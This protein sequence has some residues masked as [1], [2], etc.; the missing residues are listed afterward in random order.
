ML[1]QEFPNAKI[2]GDG[3][4]Q[5]S[6]V[7]SKNQSVSSVAV[8]TNQRTTANSVSVAKPTKIQTHLTLKPKRVNLAH[9][10]SNAPIAKRTI[11]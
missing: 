4:I 11:K 2:A 7:G 3:D 6:L 9:T 8:P 5:C 1:T 10:P